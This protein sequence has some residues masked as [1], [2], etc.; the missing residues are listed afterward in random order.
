V[1]Q[2]RLP[3]KENRVLAGPVSVLPAR[4]PAI[5]FQRGTV[6][7]AAIAI[8]EKSNRSPTTNFSMPTRRLCAT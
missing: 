2:E 3:K 8:W 1:L 7:G 5:T 4:G 6:A